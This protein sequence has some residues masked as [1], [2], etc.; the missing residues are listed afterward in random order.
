V[1]LPQDRKTRADIARW[2]SWDGAHFNK[3]FGVFAFDGLAKPHFMK[4][5]PDAML[6]NWAQMDLGASLRS[7]NRR[8]KGAIISS[9]RR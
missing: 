5:Q 3:A 8:C 9:A 1:L 4:T 2:L 6:I 7:S